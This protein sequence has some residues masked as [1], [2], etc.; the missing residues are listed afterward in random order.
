MQP[1]TLAADLPGTIIDQLVTR[2]PV[3]DEL[4]S[5]IPTGTTVLKAEKHDT[6]LD[7]DLSEQ[8]KSIEGPGQRVA[9]AQIVF[10]ATAIPG[11]SSV[12]FSINGSPT[13]VPVDDK[14]A[15]VG[16]MISRN[17]F[18]KLNPANASTTTSSDHPVTTPAPDAVTDP[19]VP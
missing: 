17:D 11:V 1:P 16:E 12:R 15:E 10:T 18:P 19:T 7:V 2:P 5:K 8:F 3:T 13:A 6:T 9:V 4:K 14:S